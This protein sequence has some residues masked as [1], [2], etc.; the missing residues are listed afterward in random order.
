MKIVFFSNFI[1]HHQVGL[2]D[3][4]YERTK[5]DFYFV[6]LVPMFDWLKSGGYADF[7]YKPYVIQAWK[8][9]KYLQLANELCIDADVALFGGPE[10]LQYQ[11]KRAKLGKLSFEVSERCLKKGL[12][13]LL[14]PRLLKNLWYYYTLFKY[15]PVY[16]LCASAYG[17]NDQYRLNTYVNRCYKW[18]YFTN[19]ETIPDVEK[20]EISHS[21]SETT[22]IM[23]CARFLKWKHPELV[24]K[25][26]ARLK[27]KGYRF[28]IDM[29]G[30]G[31]EYSKI[32]K[33]SEKLGV[34]D[35]VRF[36]GNLPNQMILN[37]M[38]RHK[39]FLFTSDRNEGW[40]AV[41]N[42]AMSNGAV[43]VGSDA[44]G[45]V[46]YLIEDCKNGMI[47]RSGKLD[48]LE[49][50]VEYLLNSPLE[51]CRLAINAYS[52]MKNIWS[53]QNAAS[54]L[55]VLISDLL[56]SNDSSIE[57]GPCSKAFPI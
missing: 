38:S 6:E 43:L 51:S 12:L 7:S 49:E 11:V 23:W 55:M 36:C 20:I 50:K 3:E 17:A 30:T 41:A 13:N 54:N 24:I 21:A 22:R 33:L 57:C 28:S 15:K 34:N 14:S 10:A 52:T 53:P 5:G 37:E 47:F 44:I 32:L 19:V 29:F 31:T 26:A 18:G 40:G 2:A 1:N 39:I 45:S 4:L 48:S 9:D 42:E 16:K 35:V 27:S 25:L 8:G 56:N 46:P